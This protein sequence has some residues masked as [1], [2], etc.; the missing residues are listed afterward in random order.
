MLVDIV[1]VVFD[2]EI[3]LLEWQAKSINKFLKPEEINEIIIVDNGSQTCRPT[4]DWYGKFKSKVRILN[5]GNLGLKVMPHLDGWR[6]QQLCK[7]LSASQSTCD[8]SLILDA[9]TLFAKETCISNFFDNHKP[10]VGTIAVSE[11]WEDAKQYLEQYFNIAINN[12]LGPGGV[13]FFFHSDTLRE[14]INHIPD[15]NTW[16]QNNLYEQTHPHRTK[17]T[18]FMLYNAFVLFRYGNYDSL[19]STEKM[20]IQPFNVADW[21]VDEFENIFNVDADTISVAEKTKTLLT[22][23]QLSRWEAFLDDKYN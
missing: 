18:E 20:T 23:E 2:Q 6:T 19:Y 5:H 10:A 21:Q 13:P 22:N 14:M 7:I 1:T 3:Y 11:Y 12:A 4:P 17:V 9:K 8:Y 16:F 15:F